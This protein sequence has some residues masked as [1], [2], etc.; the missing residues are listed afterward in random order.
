MGSNSKM[1]T[2]LLKGAGLN[3]SRSWNEAR[4]HSSAFASGTLSGDDYCSPVNRVFEVGLCICL[5]TWFASWDLTS[6]QQ[7]QWPAISLCLDSDF[8][9]CVGK[10]GRKNYKSQE[11]LPLLWRPFHFG[12]QL[13]LRNPQKLRPERALSSP[14]SSL[15]CLPI[16]TLEKHNI[17]VVLHL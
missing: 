8:W 6:H 1:A 12:C 14:L 16:T 17:G 10:A 15:I 3:M 5:E 7:K 2:V 13:V 11:A 4:L 9:W